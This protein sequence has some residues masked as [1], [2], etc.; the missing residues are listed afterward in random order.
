MARSA[1]EGDQ[2]KVRGAALVAWL[3]DLLVGEGG[4]SWIQKSIERFLEISGR[5]QL[6]RGFWGLELKG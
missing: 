3:V 5:K 1:E 4:S 6:L 2:I